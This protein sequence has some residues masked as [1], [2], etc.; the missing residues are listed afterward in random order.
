MQKSRGAVK[1]ET[2]SIRP[3]GAISTVPGDG[4][5]KEDK[6]KMKFDRSAA[7]FTDPAKAKMG[8]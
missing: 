6:A 1:V 2:T 4:G 3:Q 7:H 8:G 5:V